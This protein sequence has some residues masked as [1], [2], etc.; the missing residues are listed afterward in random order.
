MLMAFLQR[1]QHQIF[2]DDTMKL[3]T[4]HAKLKVLSSL[5]QS[6]SIVP[7]S[8]ANEERQGTSDL[9]VAIDLRPAF[10]QGCTE[11]R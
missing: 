1:C 7:Y 3:L 6:C 2:S 5:R 9:L 10:M 11:T 4:C 8:A